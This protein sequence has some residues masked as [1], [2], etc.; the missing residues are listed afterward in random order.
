MPIRYHQESLMAA[1]SPPLPPLD[2]DMRKSALR[3]F[4]Y[5]LYALGTA[6]GEERD[7]ATVNWV[8][9]VAFEPPLLAV[10][11]ENESHSIE[12]IRAAGVFALSVFGDDRREEAGILGKRWKLRPEKVDG[13]PH[14]SGVTGCPILDNALAAVECRVVGSLPAG[15]STLFVAEVV[16][17]ETIREGTPLT[18]AAAGYRHAG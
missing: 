3:S 5:G 1:Q 4:T 8:T 17:A 14:H 13:V 9:Q 16:A 7:L 11:V 15:D 12:L 10:S 2:P 18:M 6:D